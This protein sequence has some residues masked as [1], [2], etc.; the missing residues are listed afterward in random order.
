MKTEPLFLDVD[1]F[2][3][4]LNKRFEKEDFLCD[5][6]E[7]LS[8]VNSHKIKLT[9]K[10]RWI[11]VKHLYAINAL[12]K[13]PLRVEDKIGDKIY[14]I[15]EEYCFPRIYF[16]D[17]LAEA[18]E[19]IAVNDKDVLFSGAEYDNFFNMDGGKKKLW[20]ILA[21]WFSMD[22]NNWMPEGDFGQMIQDK[23]LELIPYI[24]EISGIERGIDFKKFTK[25][26]ITNLNLKWNAQSQDWACSGMEW[27]IKHCILVPFAWFDI[28]NIQYKEKDKLGIKEI[29]GFYVKPMGKLFLEDLVRMGEKIASTKGIR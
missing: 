13:T 26:L 10:C 18:S 20:L 22:W 6:K 12:L 29:K 28:I 4:D 21:W 3:E 23:I 16:M 9:P 5:F 15:R 8:Y 25:K 11:P 27:G 2:M 24:K 7:F 17:L 14:R 19:C 1:A